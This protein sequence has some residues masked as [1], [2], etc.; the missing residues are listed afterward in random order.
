VS[1]LKVAVGDG[2]F[3]AAVYLL[4]RYVRA[5]TQQTQ[6]ASREKVEQ[7]QAFLNQPVVVVTGDRILRPVEGIL[8]RIELKGLTV[9]RDSGKVVFIPMEG[10]RAVEDLLGH[11]A[12]DW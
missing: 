5:G 9:E 3:L 6:E 7:L 8:Q 1:V 12:G 10:V 4:Y 11:R 2:L